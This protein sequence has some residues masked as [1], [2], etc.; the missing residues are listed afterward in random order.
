MTDT[1]TIQALA[2]LARRTEITCKA[3]YH[4][5]RR[6]NSH[7]WFSQ[8]TLALLAVGQI[9]LSVAQAIRL[10][11][12]ISENHFNLGSIFFGVLILAYS[13]LLGMSNF[14]ARAV[15][16]HECGL[17]LG[18]LTRKLFQAQRATSVRLSEYNELSARYYNILEKHENHTRTDYLV[19]HYEYYQAHG[20]GPS[21]EKNDK[22]KLF[23]ARAETHIFHALQFS[24][25]VVSLAL[26]A[27][28]GYI[29]L[30]GV[31]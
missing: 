17:E 24:H 14:S 26:M 12:H 10:P 8:W 1:S 25:Y 28:F 19:A 16:I 22:V 27:V 5:A 20:Y 18:R 3:R 31:G 21:Q 23:L 6:L 13:L 15:R 2:E 7:N 9:T 4:A 11:L 29:A 30:I